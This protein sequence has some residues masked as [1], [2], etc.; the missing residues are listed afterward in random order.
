MTRLWLFFSRACY[1][2]A[3]VLGWM[4]RVL[5]GVCYRSL[6]RVLKFMY[7]LKLPLS[8]T[9]SV[10]SGSSS[11]VRLVWCALDRAKSRANRRGLRALERA[12]APDTLRSACGAVEARRFQIPARNG[13]SDPKPE[14]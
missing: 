5:L 14:A 8:W 2:H 13:P 3:D 6:S 11:A 4:T 12:V 9:S 1:W 10:T 7:W